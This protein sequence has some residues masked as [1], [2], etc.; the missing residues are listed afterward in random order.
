[1]HYTM[2]QCLKK[3]SREY[4]DEIDDILKHKGFGEALNF[5]IND[6]TVKNHVIGLNYVFYRDIEVSND[7]DNR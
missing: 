1:M 4:R 7:N 2:R 6:K 5:V 3:L